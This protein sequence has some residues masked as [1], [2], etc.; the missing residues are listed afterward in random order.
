LSLYDL[1]SLKTEL[2]CY[3]ACE[4]FFQ[5]P[6]DLEP[7]QSLILQKERENEDGGANTGTSTTKKYTDFLLPLPEHLQQTEVGIPDP[8]IVAQR[9]KESGIDNKISEPSKKAKK[10]LKARAELKN[11]LQ[12][13]PG[14]TR[15][16]K[17]APRPGGF[18]QI[19]D[20]E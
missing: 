2:Y 10:E 16:I 12:I 3:R 17:I 7:L 14:P 19:T 8:T 4:R 20:G 6:I 1:N 5:S 18:T 11:K 13:R 9:R 15:K